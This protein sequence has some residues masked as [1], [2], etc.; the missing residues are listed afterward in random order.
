MGKSLSVGRKIF[1]NNFLSAT[2]YFRGG[3]IFRGGG[4]YC[5]AKGIIHWG[6]SGEVF[7]REGGGGGKCL[8][9]DHEKEMFLC[10]LKVT[11]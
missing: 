1:G 10:H 5:S 8:E 9:P 2:M 7:S 4:R 3:G 11:V 6:I